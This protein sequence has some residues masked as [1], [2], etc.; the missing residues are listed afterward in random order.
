MRRCM[1]VLVAGPPPEGLIRRT[2][3][4]ALRAHLKFILPIAGIFALLVLYTA[5][6]FRRWQGQRGRP[7]LDRGKGKRRL[8]DCL[9]RA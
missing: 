5:Y 7:R 2:R 9:F 6:W 8:S 3:G 4:W 1:S